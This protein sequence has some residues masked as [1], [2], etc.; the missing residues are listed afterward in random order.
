MSKEKRKPTEKEWQKI[1]A[2]YLSGV[3][4]RHIVE[5]FPDLKLTA[6]GISNKF[7]FN[8]TKEKRD[9]IKERVEAQLLEDIATAQE[10]ANREM[11]EASQKIIK[12][13]KRYLDNEM[14]LDF[15]GFGKDGFEHTRSNT[16]NTKAFLEITKALCGVQKAQRVALNMDKEIEEKQQTPVIN[17]NFADED[18]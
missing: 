6:K 7:S 15:T 13:V 2:L 8:S 3:K 14:Y 10:N 16:I 18:G 17:I 4:P 1:R 11:I 5:K 9:K 12:V